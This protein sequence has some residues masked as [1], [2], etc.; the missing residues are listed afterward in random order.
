MTTPIVSVKDGRRSSD[1]RVVESSG[2]SI[3]Y[4]L[5]GMF[6]DET[7]K[8]SMARW[9]LLLWTYTGWL[10]IHHELRLKVGDPSLQNA[11]WQSWWAAEGFIGLAVFG[12]RIASY[13]GAGAAGAVTGIGASIRDGL[14][15]IGEQIEAKTSPTVTNTTTTINA[16]PV[17][18][19]P[20]PP[21]A[22]P[23]GESGET[24][25]PG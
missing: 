16:P 24:S 25:V 13:F 20:P 1:W 14:A 23:S 9:M 3:F 10:M 11:A 19:P 15:K 22:Q 2:K 6:V 17:D 21:P 12:P 8:P 5:L 7:G 18:T 4:Y